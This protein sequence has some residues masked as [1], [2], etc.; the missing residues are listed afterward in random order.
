M[1]ELW[2]TLGVVAF[3][4][5]AIL[6]T[7]YV[8][9]YITFYVSPKNRT[10][11]ADF[12]SLGKEFEPYLDQMRTWINEVSTFPYVSYNIKSFDGL[13]LHAKYY[14]CKKGA[15]IEIMFHG[16]R[17]NAER[18]LCGGVQRCFSLERNV[19]L[20]DQRTAG[21]SD[22]KVITFGVNEM[23]DCLAWVDFAE[24]TFGSE[25]KLILTGISMGASTVLMASSHEFP[26]NVVGVIADCGFTSAKDIIKKCIKE[27]KLPVWL[28]YPFIKLGARI[29]GGFKLE[30]FSALEAMKTCTLPVIFFHG[31]DDS[32]VPCDMSRQNFSEC[33]A[34]KKLVTMKG[35]GHG[36]CF[37]AKPEEYLEHLREF[38]KE[39]NIK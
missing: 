5:I 18:D 15:P 8:C 22:G 28:V 4:V 34:P 32:F 2:I 1:P 25:V 27:M 30:E 17:G 21:K 26:P 3:I 7:A 29:Y 10:S 37:L 16:Y 23:R 9:F 20:I 35:A 24:K 36:M 6:I 39:M 12:S 31:E 13:D 38:K 19:L 33:V 14:E 11:P